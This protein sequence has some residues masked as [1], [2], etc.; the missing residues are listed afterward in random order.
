MFDVDEEEPLRQALGEL[1][2]LG[3]RPAASI[4]MRRLRQLGVRAVRRG[5][6]P[7][8]NANA[9]ALTVREMEVLR[10]LADGLRNAA[11]GEKLFLSPRTVEHHVSAILGK[12]DAR[13]RGQ[14]V[15]KA[16]Q[17]GLLEA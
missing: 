17:L 14:A 9:A 1:Q 16:R 7:S 6:R 4:V 15:V 2:R 10:L 3:A 12:L 5:P 8:T 11:I 13:S